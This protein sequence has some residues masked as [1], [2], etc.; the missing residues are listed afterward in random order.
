MR[1]CQIAF[2]VT[3]LRRTHAWYRK[4]FGFVPSGG[5]RLFRG[6]LTSKVQGLPRAASTCW[7]LMDQQDFMQL[8]LFQFTSPPVRPLPDDW[9]PCDIGY[10]TVGLH[11]AGFDATLRRLAESGVRPITDPMGD[12]GARRACVRDPE[13]VLLELMEDDPRLPTSADRPRP[14]LPVAARSV[15]LSVADLEKAR[16][17]WVD[18]LGLT[19]ADNLPPRPPEMEALWGLEGATCERLPLWAGEILLELVQY[20]DPVGKPW[21]DGYRISDQGLLNIAFGFRDK[22]RYLDVY[23]RVIDAGYSSNWRPLTLPGWSVV[24]CNDDQGFSVELLHC[25]SWFDPFLG[26]RPKT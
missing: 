15:T 20:T 22:Q 25:K 18:T 3:D 8:E 11:V 24:Y 7:W 19:P 9:R 2:S 21:P 16:R 10:T 6:Y 5:T 4:M 13:G 23:R 12:P 14:Q 26:F 17:F 1:L